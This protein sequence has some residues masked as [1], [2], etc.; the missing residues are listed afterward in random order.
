M[1]AFGRLKIN[2]NSLFQEV[3]VLSPRLCVERHSDLL[4]P[5]KQDLSVNASTLGQNIKRWEA[6]TLLPLG[7]LTL[8]AQ[9]QISEVQASM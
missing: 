4:W 5:I 6:S 2:A 3:R 1:E 9:L 7:K 8:R